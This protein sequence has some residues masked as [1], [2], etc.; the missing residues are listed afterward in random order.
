MLS[1][2]KTGDVIEIIVRDGTY[3]KINT[4]KFNASDT[5]QGAMIL[6]DLMG[7]YGF[8]PE[9][10]PKNIKDEMDKSEPDFLDMKVN[11]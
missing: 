4:W 5:K 11:W 6:R 7:K 10:I 8:T 9:I 3:R 2:N 1:Y